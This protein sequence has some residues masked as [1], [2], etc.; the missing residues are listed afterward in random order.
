MIRAEF[1]E[2]MQ[3]SIAAGTIEHPIPYERYMDESFAASQQPAA[4]PL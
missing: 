4:I 2:L 1:E 3:L